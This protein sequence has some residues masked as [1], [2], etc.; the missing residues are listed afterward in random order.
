[1]F[2]PF[3]FLLLVLTFQ[4][5][6]SFICYPEVNK[7]K[8]KEIKGGQF[9]HC[10][11]SQE[12][13]YCD[14]QV[15]QSN[16]MSRHHIFDKSSWIEILDRGLNHGG[17]HSEAAKQN[18]IAML[19]AIGAPASVVS[20][21]DNQSQQC[22]KITNSWLTWLP[23]NLSLGPAPQDRSFDPSNSFDNWALLIIPEEYQNMFIIIR[24]AIT[25]Y[26]NMQVAIT[27]AKLPIVDGPW[28]MTL[29]QQANWVRAYDMNKKIKYCPKVIFDKIYF[30]CSN[31]DINVGQEN[32]LQVA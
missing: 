22:S 2:Q 16:P 27:L 17:I 8:P 30:K 24:N 3:Y 9:D 11:L 7:S 21:L 20:D 10:N 14:P 4:I 1:M 18:I 5:G 26:D 25:N 28:P 32:F 29:G 15:G 13:I 19:K 12:I 31:Y 23:V 6:N